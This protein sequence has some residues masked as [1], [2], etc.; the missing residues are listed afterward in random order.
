M[1]RYTGPSCRLC[2]RQG[3]KLMLKG[4]RCESAKCPLERQWRNNPPGMHSWRRGR[5][6][7]YGIRL[8]EK[9]KVKRFYGVYERQF[10][11]YFRQA[12]RQ[13]A[14]TGAALLSLLER[15][16]DNVVYKLGFAPSR[17]AARLTIT[18]GHI[19]V[20]G[21]RMGI[22]SYLVKPGDKISVKP[23]EKSVKLVRARLE[24]LG[25]PQLQ[26]WLSLDMA[27]LEGTVLAMPTRDDVMIPVEENLIV[28]L[29][30]R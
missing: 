19:Y 30:S 15:R 23:S 27:K 12:E 25:E 2:R 28:E 20:N 7:E 11:R 16:L 22:P 26:N 24:E 18:H 10:M 5:P 1:G 9:Q 13:K 6:S 29:C 4:A 17:A 3:V 21:R 14:N 8:R